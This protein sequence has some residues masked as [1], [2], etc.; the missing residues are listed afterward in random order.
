MA[1]NVRAIVVTATI[2]ATILAVRTNSMVNLVFTVDLPIRLNR[3]DLGDL[4]KIKF[5]LHSE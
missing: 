1:T 4:I 3:S 5:S 2:P